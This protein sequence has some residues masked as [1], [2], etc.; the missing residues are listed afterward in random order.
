MNSNFNRSLSQ[1]DPDLY[2]TI[3]SESSREEEGL[4][5]IA[6]ENYASRAVM[7]AQGS[8]LTNKY[9]E[10]YPGKRY[11]GGCVN[12]DRAEALAI[13]RVCKL[14]GAEAANVQPHSG[15]SANMGVYLS[16]LKPGDTILGMSL[17][18]G[19]HLTHGSPVNFS[20]KLFRAVH[21]GLNPATDL[22]DYDQIREQAKAERPKVLIAGASAYSRI[23]DFKI[24]GEIANEV[25]AKLV[26]DMAHIAGLI[27]AGLHPSPI[28][29]AAYTTSTTHKTL[30][31]PRG[32]I[33][34][35]SQENL[36]AVN[37]LIFPGIQGGPLMHVIA[38]KAVA[39]GEALT[40]EFKTYQEQVIR[41][42]K[43]LAESLIGLGFRLVTNGT[44]NH[45]ML[46]DLSQSHTG[47]VTGKEAEAWLDLA[48]ITVNKN[49]VP[50]EKRSPFITSGIRVGTPAMTTR[51]LKEAEMKQI[52][53]WIRDAVQSK[54]DA[55]TLAKI[56]GSVKELCGR[57]PVYGAHA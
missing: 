49:T 17:S 24:F 51:G 32:G 20:G 3:T 36:K 42:A 30:R 15:S 23:I 34:L 38:A 19:G 9:A 31:G 27:A 2:S 6:S 13:E 29:H 52:A 44:D 22:L 40:P 1:T 37:S 43:T 7:E 48:G 16:L 56:R 41:N 11:Y 55:G 28:P 4:E 46:I 21:Y 39:F 45:L 57:F 26:V 50:N 33:I 18:H 8:I 14:F 54:G 10:G 35:C 25:G 47:E 12:V 5:L 53:L